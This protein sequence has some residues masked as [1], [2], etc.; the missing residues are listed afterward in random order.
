MRSVIDVPHVGDVRAASTCRA[1]GTRRP[2]SGARG[3]CRRH[4]HVV[5]RAAGQQLGLDDL[6]GVED[7]VDDL[8]PGLL[9]ELFDDRRIDVVRPVVDVDDLSW[10]WA[11]N[12]TATARS[13]AAESRSALRIMEFSSV[14]SASRLAQRSFTA[15]YP[16]QPIG[17]F[18]KRQARKSA[19]ITDR[20]GA[21]GRLPQPQR[22][23]R[24][25]GLIR[26]RD[27][28]GAGPGGPLLAAEFERRDGRAAPGIRRCRR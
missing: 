9:G 7:V 22:R 13:G 8:D 17:L 23:V 2:G 19:C 28:G 21:A 26:G 27:A 4:H 5:A 10:A 16:V 14:C 18:R 24:Q 12:E 6:V 20:D 3:N 15:R 25:A 11:E 1:S